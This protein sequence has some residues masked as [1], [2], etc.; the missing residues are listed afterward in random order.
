MCLF[1]SHRQHVQT[2]DCAGRISEAF[3]TSAPQLDSD[4][5]SSFT[6]TQV[7]SYLNSYRI[8]LQQIYSG[9]P[10]F[11]SAT[12]GVAPEFPDSTMALYHQSE[13]AAVKNQSLKHLREWC[14]TEDYVVVMPQDFW[15]FHIF[16]AL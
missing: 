13:V 8:S 15:L 2:S 14:L 12:H 9:I 10:G 4:L 6:R 1:T 16:V 5:S 11:L 7:T 3:K